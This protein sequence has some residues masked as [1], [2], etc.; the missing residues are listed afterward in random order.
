[1]STINEDI[2]EAVAL[3][4]YHYKFHDS[5]GLAETLELINGNVDNFKISDEQK[6]ELTEAI[7]VAS[8]LR[9][10]PD[11]I[12]NM[13]SREG[14][15]KLASINVSARQKLGLPEMVYRENIELTNEKEDVR[16]YAS[17]DEA[18]EAVHIADEFKPE[19]VEPTM[20][21]NE[22]I[23][24]IDKVI[25]EALGKEEAI[26][27]ITGTNKDEGDIDLSNLTVDT[28]SFF[29]AIPE[30]DESQRTR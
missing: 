17:F 5:I 26:P 24:P 14:A 7:E 13:L 23:T 30:I 18:L 12:I 19:E 20:D 29:D 27:T 28:S 2:K 21:P 11:T 15:E 8:D 25:E 3:M 1:M 10:L 9:V 6:K 22:G 16:E 4:D